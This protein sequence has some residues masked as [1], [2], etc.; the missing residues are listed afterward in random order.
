MATLVSNE[1]GEFIKSLKNTGSL[2]R[3]DRREKLQGNGTGGGNVSV[4]EIDGGNPLSG[5]SA[6]AYPS[7]AALRDPNTMGTSVTIY[8]VEIGLDAALPQGTIVLCHTMQC[9]VTGGSENAEPEEQ[10]GD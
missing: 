6:T 10:E 4:C 9:A 7:M 2:L 8:P 1:T 5:Y 3:R